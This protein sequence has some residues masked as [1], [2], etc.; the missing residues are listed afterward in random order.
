MS[1]GTTAAGGLLRGV[2]TGIEEG[3]AFALAYEIDVD[4]AWR[5]R[6]AVV[7]SLLPGDGAE[8]E[9]ARNGEDEWSV[10]GRHRPE[11]DGIVDVDLEASAMTNTLPAHRL[12]LVDRTPGPAAYVRLDLT[13][14]ALEQWYGPTVPLP[15][16]A[17]RVGYL[18]PR[19]RADFD[20]TYDASGLV[21][22]YP[23]L[24]TR[25]L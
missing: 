6:R 2:V 20:L 3:V 24:A 11:L 17:R 1:P 5:T 8:V 12:E 16:D 23:S 15:E 9:L 4:P 18:A 22:D 19:F 25:L 10:D 13:V 14:E 7:R 21:V